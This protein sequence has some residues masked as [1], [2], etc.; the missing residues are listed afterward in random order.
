MDTDFILLVG[1]RDH[2]DLLRFPTDGGEFHGFQTKMERDANK[3]E[4]VLRAVK[5]AL[6]LPSIDSVKVH[7][8]IENGLQDASGRKFQLAIVEVESQAMQAPEEWQTLPI[9]L[10]KMEKG[11]ARLIYNKAMQVYAGAMTEDVAALEVDEEVRERLRKLE[12]E[13]KL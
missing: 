12:D 10:R 4:E 9:I 13:G 7:T 6:S 11:P 1:C 8:F 2:R 3:L 5:K